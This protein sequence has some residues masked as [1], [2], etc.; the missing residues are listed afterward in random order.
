VYVVTSDTPEEDDGENRPVINSQN[1]EQGNN[2]R[3]EKEPAPAVAGREKVFLSAEE[4]QMI[5]APINYGTA[6]PEESRR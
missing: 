5:K 2:R 6:I 3:A 1:F 4:W